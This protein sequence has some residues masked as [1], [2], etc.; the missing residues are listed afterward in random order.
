MN[1]SRDTQNVLRNLAWKN[2]NTRQYP[3]NQCCGL[4]AD[5]N[6]AYHMHL[7]F[8]KMLAKVSRLQRFLIMFASLVYAAYYTCFKNMSTSSSRCKMFMKLVAV[9]LWSKF[10][11]VRHF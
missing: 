10:E 8:E 9:F 6:K 7:C 1:I 11:L 3:T 5:T 4:N 2:K